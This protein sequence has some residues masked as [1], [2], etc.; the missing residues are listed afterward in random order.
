MTEPTYR[1][2]VE[3][4]L[5]RI[6]EHVYGAGCRFKAPDG[7]WQTV[8]NPAPWVMALAVPLRQALDRYEHAR[9]PR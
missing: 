7:T 6:E 5:A 3:H 1:Q 9:G 8:Q 4:A 2:V